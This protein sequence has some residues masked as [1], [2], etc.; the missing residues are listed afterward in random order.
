MHAYRD[1]IQSEGGRVVQYAAILYPGPTERYDPGLEAL[2]VQPG[3][4]GGFRQEIRRLNAERNKFVAKKQKE[5]SEQGEETLDSAMIKAV[6]EQ[7]SKRN[8]RFE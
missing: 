6:R 2:S 1:A 7:A 3:A 8:F 5:L 4:E